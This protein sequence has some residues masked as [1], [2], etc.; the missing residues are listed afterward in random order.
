VITFAG[1]DKAALGEFTAALTGTIKQGK[2]TVVQTVPGFTLKL[3]APMTLALTPE[4][5]Q[6][7]V[8][9]ELKAKVKVERNPAL[10]G[11]ITLAFQNL[12]KGVTVDAVKIPADQSEVEVVLK[13]AADAALGA[14]SNLSVKGEAT[15]G[16][17]KLAATSPNVKLTVAAAAAAP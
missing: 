16:K 5:E 6:V 3:Q 8:G 9:K 12:P 13:V 15:V 10:K 2:T 4:A 14:I 17:A 7:E 11:E 1:T